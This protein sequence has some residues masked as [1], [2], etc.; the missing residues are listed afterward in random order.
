MAL[1][2]AGQS[3]R[4]PTFRSSAPPAPRRIAGLAG[5]GTWCVLWSGPKAISGVVRVG[6]G[7]GVPARRRVRL[8]DRVSGHLM[9]E[10]WSD[11]VTGAF[12]FQGLLQQA[13]DVRADDFARIYASDEAG[14]VI[15][16]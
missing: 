14:L 3:L 13:F 8:Y 2:I 12:T 5:G 9:R 7:D 11:E 15:P 10:T 16:V 1:R 4:L 6:P